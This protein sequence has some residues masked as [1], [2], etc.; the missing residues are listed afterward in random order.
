LRA[1][2]VLLVCSLA[3]PGAAWAHANLVKVTPEN[4]AVLSS[5][6][7][8]VRLVFDDTVRPASGIK[9]VRN[10]GGA[11]V[12]AGKARV[13]GGRTLV[14]PLR[15]GLSDGDYT[16]LW[17][18]VSDDG[19]TVAGVA[20]FG[21]GAGRP[22][23]TAVLTAS[24]GPSV[25]DVASRWFLFAGLLT[26]VG[27][28]CFRFFVAPVPVRLFLGAFLLV[29]IGVS[30]LLHDVP[31]S[32]R[33]GGA[34]VAVA[35]VAALGALLSA[36]TPVY[37][38]LEPGVYVAAVLLLPGPSIAGHALDP[39]RSPLQVVDDVIH[40]AAAS[41]WLG[42]LLALGLALRRPGDHALLM[43]RFSNIAVV[44]VAVLAVTGVVRALTELHSVGQ[45]W[46]T[47]Y[48]RA[49]VVKTVLLGALVGI[50]WVNRYRLVPR[51]RTAALRRNIVGELL[52]F[53]GLIAAVALL[54]DLRPGRDRAAAA[55]LATGP[56]PL[57]ASKAV[58][59]ARES[60]DYAV[61]LAY[62]AP[63]EEVTVLGPD[64]E[65]VNGLTVKVNG[66]KAGSCGAGCYGAFVPLRRTATVTVNGDRLIFA[67]PARPTPAP[68]LVAR[69]T[70]TFRALRSVH[71]VE[72]LASSPRNKV[73]SDFTL[74]RPNR[75][76]YRIRGG[77]SG[78]IIG[79]RRWDRARGQPWVES[80][81]TPLQQPEPIWAG[82]FTNAFL[83]KTTPSTYVVSFM[84]PLG[85]T[86]F[87]VTLD[88]RT[89]RPRTLR[90]TTASHFMTHR[91][92]RFNA[93]PRIKP[94]TGAR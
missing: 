71:Y 21:V 45:L 94:P 78:V 16:V 37:P 65:G 52:L 85:P 54:T 50:G 19:H 30:G 38:V 27:A 81:Q 18:A 84:K 1:L 46:T 3:A 44:S 23:P 92:T 76:E 24:N 51:L 10:D 82:H 61:A 77:A 53:A 28:A 58:V 70:R 93:P 43:R 83:L 22:P 79:S 73:V 34:M 41:V 8:A 62:R 25:K 59:Q 40:V 75:L 36:L 56:P 72:R 9:A 55:V 31:V 80:G 64:G 91:Y 32:S 57:P 14:V 4:G 42:G 2:L 67:V 69:A 17:R 87:T 88:R 35:I 49:L 12:L 13:V 48:G 90:M 33:F 66:V 39:G 6:P 68:A 20:A 89:L 86:W 11:S 60:G 74:E 29:F 15:S 63:G 7:T 47:G 26:A 5:P